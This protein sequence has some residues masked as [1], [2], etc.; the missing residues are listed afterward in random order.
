VTISIRAKLLAAFLVNL[1]LMLGIG[2]F[3]IIQMANINER[4]TF[5][6]TKTIPSLNIIGDFRFAIPRYRGLQSAII[7][8]NTDEELR[9]RLAEMKDLEGEMNTLFQKYAENEASDTERAL[10]E[11][12]RATWP[13][14]VVQTNQDLLPAVQA[15]NITQMFAS[16]NQMKPAYLDLV[17]MVE[18]LNDIN[19]RL[20]D[21]ATV[22]AQAT[23]ETSK[24][25]ILGMTIATLILSAALGLFLSSAI[26]RSITL[27]TTAA[28]A[29]AAGD[30]TRT[31]TIKSRD[32]LGTLAMAFNQ[33]TAS[34]HSITSQVR[35]ANNAIAASAAEILAATTQQSAGA[36]EQS[37]A[38]AQTTTTVEEVKVIALQ[39]AQQAGQVAHDS[40][41]ALNAA[42]QG[43]AAVEETVNGM[44]QIRIQV[45]SI[46]QTILALSE[47]AQAIGTI[48]ATV[49]E[50]ADQSNLLA[51]NAA[52]EAARAGEQGKSF[53]VVAQHVRDL[54]ERSKGATV[55]VRE[56]L[57]E[58]QKATSTA[59]LVTEEGTKGV[60]AG[61]KLAAQAGQVI[62]KIAQEVE[63]GAQANVQIAA[64]A[65]Q[66]TAGMEQIS[67][68]MS[69]IQQ[70]TTQ[71]QAST[72]QA[73]RAAQDLHTLAQ[74]L[75]QAI[76]TYQ[77]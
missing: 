76:A 55:Q 10:L 62:H 72:R 73:E 20:A 56:L 16:F 48:V 50:L 15:K 7:A 3:A 43:T 75:Q 32:E 59:V 11:R 18:D 74:S 57:S 24:N 4:S 33:M 51:L 5:L 22:S 12:L 35:Q 42:R 8:A 53:A 52:I 58:I 45:E 26:T 19:T 49:S 27:L 30:L 47:Q 38:I 9:I 23:Y 71:A 46:A 65:Q 77:L 13:G 67:Q 1:L 28:A 68:A 41:I 70:A 44:S 61:G 66:Q 37:A 69:S 29:V 40:Q 6:G 63:G 39:T 2:I 36:A 60:D 31:V 21:D 17:K 25:L 54:A 34:L 64:A 14:F